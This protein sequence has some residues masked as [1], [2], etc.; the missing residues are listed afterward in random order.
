MSVPPIKL[1]QPVLHI[2]GLSIKLP[3]GADRALAVEAVNL[4]L[5]AGQTLCV[6]GES[7]SGKSLIAGAVMGL[8]PRPRVAPVAGRILFEGQD[9]IL[10]V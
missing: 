5:R 2:E 7:G 8:L 3:K 6:V 9:P 1:G 10:F 4:E